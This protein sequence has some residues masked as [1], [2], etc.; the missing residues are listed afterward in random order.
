MTTVGDKYFSARCQELLDR[1]DDDGL[2]ITRD[3]V[4][5]AKVVRLEGTDR[6][7]GPTAFSRLNGILKGKIKINGD[8]MSTGEKWDAEEG[9]C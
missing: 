8:I 7:G 4:P 5:Y 1:L 9:K 3:G 2:V 6:D